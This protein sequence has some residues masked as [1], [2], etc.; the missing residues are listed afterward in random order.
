MVHKPHPACIPPNDPNA[1]VWRYVDLAKFLDLL[2]NRRL[3]FSRLDQLGDP[4]EGFWPKPVI[5]RFPGGLGGSETPDPR[6]YWA[7]T[8][9]SGVDL[10]RLW[11]FANCWHISEHES[12]A[13]WKVYAERGVAVQSTY[14]RLCDGLRADRYNDVH[15]GAIR[16]LDY[17]QDDL[18]GDNSLQAVMSKRKSFE[19]EREL[20]A[21]TV[22]IREVPQGGLSF[23][24]A[25]GPYHP[26]GLY[27]AVDP[28]VLIEKIYV[29]PGRPVWFRDLV[30]AVLKRYDL[31]DIP[32]E[33]SDVDRR[34]DYV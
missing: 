7:R 27:V 29:S 22:H 34:P 20:R 6:E 31:T 32:I 8:I 24:E 19:Y 14:S 4:F 5:D 12:A 3:H 28:S 16:Y 21:V 9:R 10:N 17:D 30:G 26:K 15:V 11:A 1:R 2:E 25:F 13:M 18:P 33:A 23:E